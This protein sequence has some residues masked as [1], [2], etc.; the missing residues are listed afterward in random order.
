MDLSLQR[1]LQYADEGE[2]ML[3]RIVTGDQSWM[4][5]YEPESKRASMQWKQPQFTFN[6]EL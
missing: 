5:H 2:D 1:L 3:N 6:K 4:H